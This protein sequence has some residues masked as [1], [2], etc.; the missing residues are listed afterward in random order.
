M[1]EGKDS[2]VQAGQGASS[3]NGSEKFEGQTCRRSDARASQCKQ[4][5]EQVVQSEFAELVELDK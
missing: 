2:S 4:D 5:E 1:E 3:A